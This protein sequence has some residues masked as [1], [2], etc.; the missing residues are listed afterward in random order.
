MG[1]YSFYPTKNLGALG[2][3][4]AVTANDP[5]LAARVRSLRQYGWTSRYRSHSRGRNS[6]LDE[7]QAAILRVKLPHLAGWNERRRAI[8]DTY[9]RLLAGAALAT[10]L[11]DDSYVAHLYVV[12][13]PDRDRMRDCLRAASIGSDV[14]YPLADHLQESARGESWAKCHLPVT[15]TCCREV[16]TLPCF[17]ELRDEEVE[18]VAQAVLAVTASPK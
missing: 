6:R 16:L 10:P 9:N 11:V 12:R 18:A 17:P 2:D 1:C 8:A 5:D 7:M 4:G 14:H 15:E 3:G 13:C